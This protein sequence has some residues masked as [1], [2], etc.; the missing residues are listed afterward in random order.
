M[1]KLPILVLSCVLAA[2][3][4]LVLWI[5]R[6]GASP[7]PASPSA[8]ETA[9]APAQSDIAALA[10]STSAPLETDAADE[11]KL[12]SESRTGA[13]S[14]DAKPGA[15]DPEKSVW[16]SGTVRAACA[17]DGALEVVALARDIDAETLIRQ[18]RPRKKDSDEDGA[19][20]ILSRSA[21][22]SDGSF[23]LA[24]PPD[25]KHAFVSVIGRYHYLPHAQAV[26]LPPAREVVLAPQCGACIAGSIVLPADADAKTDDL[27]DVDAELAPSFDGMRGSV[28]SMERISRTTS[29]HE[30][31]FEFRALPAE[32]GYEITVAPK[33]FAATR[34]T[35]KDLVPGRTTSLAIML[36]H[37][38]TIRGGVHDASGAAVA[39]ATVEAA[40]PGRLFGFDNKTVREAK[41]AADG[42]FELAA[43][44]PGRV[45]VRAKSDRYLES[46]PLKLELADGGSVN[47]AALVLTRGKSVSGTLAWADGS[48]AASVAVDLKFDMSQMYGMGAFNA[49]RGSK[50][51]ATS[52]A[53]GAFE[54]DGLGDGP[55][56]LEAEAPP[57]MNGSAAS[58]ANPSSDASVA[59]TDESEK[60]ADAK[61]G[62]IAD[63][64]AK[65]KSS[66]AKHDK[67]TYWHSRAD[68]VAGGS[69]N[70]ALVLRAPE[71]LPGK[72]VDESGAPV[73]KF[74]VDAGRVGKGPLANFGQ[75][76]RNETF[77]DSA[78]VFLLAGLN[79][80]HWKLSAGAEGFAQSDAIELDIPR[81]S[82]AQPIVI[83]L[84]HGASIKGFVKSPSGAPIADADIAID[85]GKPNWQNMLDAAS[86]APKA[87]SQSDGA[88]VL[89]GLRPGKIAIY[90]KHKKFARSAVVSN[91]VAAAQHVEG[92][93]LVLREGGTLTG[94]V[95][96]ETGAPAAGM[97]VQANETKIFDQQMTFSDGRGQFEIEHLEPGAYQV[98]A[99]PTG[100]DPSSSDGG[101]SSADR[102]T[103]DGDQQSNMMDMV[104]KMKTAFVDI[105]DGEKTHVVLGAPPADPVHV[106]GRVTHSGA[107]YAGSMIAFVG[108][109]KAR[110]K[111]MKTTQVDKEGNYSVKL[112]EPGNYVVSVQKFQGTGQQNVVEFSSSIPKDKEYKLDFALP[113]A[114]ISGRVLGPD[115][116]P[117]PG[118]RVS[119]HPESALTAG[120]MW[121]GQYSESATDV[122]GRFD[123][124]ALRPGKY[125]L[126]VGGM[127]LGG[128]FGDDGALGRQVK[129]DVR[130]SEGEW[131]KDVDFRLKK[132]GVIDVEVVDDTG[133]PVSEAA[134]FARNKDGKLL[135]RFSLIATD[136]SGKCKYGGLEPG[137][138]FLSARKTPVASPDSTAV[139]VEEGQ[140][141]S[142]KL[143]L[144]AGTVLVVEA[145]DSDSKAVKASIS[146]QDEDGREV[147]GM[148]ALSE[149]MKLF[150]EGGFSS[151]Q[152]RVGPL[153]PGKYRVRATLADGK[154]QMKPVTLN[155]QPER[156]LAIHFM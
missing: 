22:A 26:D 96:A 1:K 89:D 60:S 135:D 84:V 140:H 67:S 82:D 152:Q 108:E 94:E 78:G 69:K 28:M 44:A 155:G 115:G 121:G 6:E 100:A 110:L 113:T 142:A 66:H 112:D 54:I 45:V 59:A 102:K 15:W 133:A 50:G 156:S 143:V 55:F 87:K 77:D 7:S 132:S 53:D 49:L 52:G 20:A 36:R 23:K 83:A 85:N 56:T 3:G 134:V 9:L 86:F 138:Y 91:D 131:M 46:D 63:A 14:A 10:T 65:T 13:A 123:V 120:T 130:L 18:L 79:E 11:Q 37:G 70:V 129:S 147:G 124:Q 125:T 4:G 40:L 39:N 145:F 24:Y 81:K 114:R 29:V 38:G 122:D 33:R 146:V 2:A 127:M 153:P 98:I 106:F 74:H 51:S 75:E 35:Q 32:N 64:T 48:P 72:V 41:S 99:M 17:D 16:L 141:S 93:E 27:E 144:Q 8:S 80:G 12:E 151:T 31:A 117:A 61:S 92:I 43:V 19:I 62:A 109:G 58:G 47:D 136:S 154:S 101:S 139:R 128:L 118:T 148:L 103:S 116:D 90:A 57:R 95:Y 105:K 34:V 137:S 149:I 71:G 126:I 88:F 68:G 104:S 119:L 73:T 42:S 21:V 30:R 150:N 5:A 111:A 25:T 107:P 97:M 76:K